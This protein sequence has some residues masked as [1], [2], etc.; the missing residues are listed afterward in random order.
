MGVQY[1]KLHLNSTNSYTFQQT[2]PVMKGEL[3]SLG[4]T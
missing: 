1:E 2:N 4:E 3:M